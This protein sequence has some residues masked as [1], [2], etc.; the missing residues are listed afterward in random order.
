MHVV[1]GENLDRS[2]DVVR[3]IVGGWPVGDAVATRAELGQPQRELIDAT[4]IGFDNHLKRHDLIARARNMDHMSVPRRIVAAGGMVPG[5]PR[6]FLA[7]VDRPDPSHTGVGVDRQQGHRN[8][9]SNQ[10]DEAPTTTSAEP[11]RDDKRPPK[12]GFMSHFLSPRSAADA[13]FIAVRA[14]AC[15]RL[16]SG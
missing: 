3:G 15:D 13:S 11:L 5:V 7:V 9:E 4:I 12:W 8:R 10:R 6:D 1:N 14:S 2:I 16:R